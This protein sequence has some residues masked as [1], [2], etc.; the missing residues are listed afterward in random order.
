MLEL[1][2]RK[3]F[4]KNTKK[5]KQSAFCLFHIFSD[6]LLNELYFVPVKRTESTAIATKSIEPNSTFSSL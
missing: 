3:L 1:N 2:N 6:S 5:P 4:K